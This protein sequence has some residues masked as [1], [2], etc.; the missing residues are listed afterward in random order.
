ML[1]I[2]LTGSMGSGKSTV[3]KIIADKGVPTIDADTLAKDILNNDPPTREKISAA[4]GEDVYDESGRLVPEILA[5]QV[6]GEIKKVATLNHIVHPR[7]FE[8]VDEIT[9]ELSAAGQKV[10]FIEAALFFETGW[11]KQVDLMVTVSAPEKLRIK[12]IQKRSHLPIKQIKARLLHQLSDEEKVARADVVIKNDGS[13]E[14]LH[15]L[16]DQFLSENRQML[17]G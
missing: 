2:G 14:N 11:D 16:V 12:R 7:V 5:Q 13:L 3:R 15:D 6:F 8:K 9:A 4:F 1:K 10:V 17:S